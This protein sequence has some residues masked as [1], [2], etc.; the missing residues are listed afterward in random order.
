MRTIAFDIVYGVLEQERHSDELFHSLTGEGREDNRKEC[1]RQ[2]RSFLRR[3][4]YG[5]IERAI[6]LD[7]VIGRYAKLPVRKMKPVVRTA[8]RMGAYEI[9]F[10][11]AVPAAATCNEMVSL[12]RKKKCGNLCGFVNGVLRN[13]A[14]EPA[15]ELRESVTAGAMPECRR[16]SL[17]YSVPEELVHMLIQAY[18]KR[19]VKKM[20]ASF[21]EERPVT[22]RVQTMNAS[23][24]Q[25][26]G[27]L[28]RA[29]VTVKDG[30]YTHTGL[31]IDHFDRVEK[32]P[33]F[34]EGHF[35]V[36]DESSMLPVLVSGVEPGHTV[37][38]VCSSPG[39][40]TFH[41][42]DILQGR[43]LVSARDISSRKLKRIMENAARLRAEHVQVKVWDASVPDEEWRE[44]A[45][46]V[47]ADVPCSG[48]GVIGKKPEIKYHAMK[49]AADLP[50]IQKRI[51]TGAVTALKPG[52]TLIYSTCTVHPRENEEMA[53]WIEKN[54]PLQPVSLDAYL[55]ETLRNGMTR[56]GM[57]QILPGIQHGD[58][59]FVAKFKKSED[60]KI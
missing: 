3:L 50:E 27:E 31:F 23:R 33:G 37:I 7:A 12:V 54:L 24:E 4:S 18:G 8:L 25:V 43:G 58:G 22:I 20:L 10:M 42:A 52:G 34:A 45:D 36:Q 35:T 41:A 16:L 17:L 48:I 40:K 56:L 28:M 59:F 9:L 49:H 44:R 46:V 29:G 53:E 55:P 57:L 47:F 51:V 11:D 21:Y 15:A 14:R 19:T 2:E 38:D 26:R 32:L 13:M 60:R 30:L 39:G 1:S 6:F 5:T